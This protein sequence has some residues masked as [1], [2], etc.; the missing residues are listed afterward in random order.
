[1]NVVIGYD[2]QQQDR[3]TNSVRIVNFAT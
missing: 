1:L 2:S 3:N